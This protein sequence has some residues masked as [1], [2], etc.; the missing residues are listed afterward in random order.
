VRPLPSA[1]TAE[2]L[3]EKGQRFWESLDPEERAL[4]IESVSKRD[5]DH[6]VEGFVGMP[7]NFAD[8]W[9]LLTTDK[10]FGK[11]ADGT[12]WKL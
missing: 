7:S 6:D 5:L 4:F 9:Y 2:R 10:P 12:A 8:V 1:T 3:L 11:K